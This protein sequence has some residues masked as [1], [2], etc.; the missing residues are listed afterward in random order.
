MAAAAGKTMA[1]DSSRFSTYFD[2]RSEFDIRDPV[3]GKATEN[4]EEFLLS[5]IDRRQ[6]RFWRIEDISAWAAGS[7]PAGSVRHET[8]PVCG[9]LAL[10]D[11]VSLPHEVLP[12][13]RGD[14]IALAGWFHE[15][16]QVPPKW[17]TDEL[18]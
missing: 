15:S 14:R 1:S 11:S 18:V 6:K 10:F 9:T 8:T 2:S 7:D 12:T 13:L 4:F 5:A 16:Q 17:F 3:T